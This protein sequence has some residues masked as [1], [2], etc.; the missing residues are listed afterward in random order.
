LGGRFSK[1]QHWRGRAQQIGDAAGRR[2][3][4]HIMFT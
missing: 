3:L 4:G 2:L 1:P